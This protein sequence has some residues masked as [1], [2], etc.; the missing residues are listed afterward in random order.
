MSKFK[1]TCFV[2][3]T[4]VDSLIDSMCEDCF[5]NQFPPIT[6]L[7]S[8]S[9]KY[10][11]QCKKITFNNAQITQEEFEQRLPTI[12]KKNLIINE[13]YILNKINVKNFE[14]KGDKVAFSFN[15]ECDLKN[16]K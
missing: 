8:I 5:K 9:T 11:N 14:I 7:K 2:C 13:N 15:I 6:Q 12:L 1:K 3:G 4:K 16:K 10:C